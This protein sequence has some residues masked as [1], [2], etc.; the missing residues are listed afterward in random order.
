MTDAISSDN[1][2]G[3]TG[4]G[5]KGENGAGAI[6]C[7][8]AGC[9]NVAGNGEAPFPKPAPETAQIIDRLISP[10]H[11]RSLEKLSPPVSSSGPHGRQGNA[12]TLYSAGT[13]V[14]LRIH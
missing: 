6:S 2:C 13:D 1:S 7:D 11:F 10:D 8:R 4:Y 3:C 9:E 5:A 14:S 12:R